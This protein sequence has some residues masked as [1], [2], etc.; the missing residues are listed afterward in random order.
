MTKWNSIGRLNNGRA[1]DGDDDA[2]EFLFF[3]Q[4]QNQD[5]RLALLWSPDDEQQGGSATKKC[6]VV[7]RVVLIQFLKSHD[8]SPS[9][10][11]TNIGSSRT[12]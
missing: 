10:N 12:L 7:D 11:T 5:S 3:H 9:L 8:S 2:I 1:D 6:A 4:K